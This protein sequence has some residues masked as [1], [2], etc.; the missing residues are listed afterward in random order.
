MNNKVLFV[1][2]HFYEYHKKIEKALENNGFIV[3]SNYLYKYNAVF[4]LLKLFSH[5]LKNAYVDFMMNRFLSKIEPDTYDY[6]FFV[7]SAQIDERFMKKL[8]LKSPT[9]KYILY[10]W[11][12]LK[13]HNYKL[14]ISY[15]DR[16]FSYD[17]VDCLNNKG[18]IYLPLFYSTES[19]VLE[20]SREID[21]S[22]IGNYDSEDRQMLIDKFRVLSQKFYLNHFFYCYMKFTT[23]IKHLCQ[24]KK[25]I[26]IKNKPLK[27]TEFNRVVRSS[28]VIIDMPNINN[29]G[30]TMRTFETLSSKT[31]LITTNLNIINEPFYNKKNIMVVKQNQEIDEKVLLDF[32][33]SPFDDTI[34]FDD[35]YIDN[36]VKNIFK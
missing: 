28:K 19:I 21:I 33:K 7:Q 32:I 1:Y 9:S 13:F 36:W 2:I 18:L 3:E 12:S 22:F 31:K 25:N 17:P 5:K 8:K 27:Y 34:P 35:Y 20:N 11:D 16:T 24:G 26:N 15:F 29:N 14:L 6:I 30:L 10:N 4:N 23:Y